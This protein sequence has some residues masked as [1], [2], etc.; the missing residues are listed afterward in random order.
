M[1]LRISW[2]LAKVPVDPDVSERAGVHDLRGVFHPRPRG[3]GCGIYAQFV[4]HDLTPEIFRTG[5]R[6]GDDN[7]DEK[8]SLLYDQHPHQMFPF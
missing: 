6:S 8:C 1:P 7:T 3:T 4:N 2:A 5:S